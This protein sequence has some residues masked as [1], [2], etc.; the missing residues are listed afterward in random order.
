M[1]IK[2]KIEKSDGRYWGTT[3][4]VPGVVVADGE[5]IND[6]KDN[7]REAV[8][9]YLEAAEENDT[10]TYEL[11]KNGIDFEYEL[12]VSEIFSFFEVINKGEFA[13]SIGINP[14]LF[15][16]YTN[17]KKQTYISEKRAKEIE[18]GLHRLGKELLNVKL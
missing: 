4:N 14:T 16:Q 18:N 8:E 3:Q 11:Y 2:V 9:L 12:E 7:M 10:E 17:A 15:R 5:S 1:A 6:L 13:K